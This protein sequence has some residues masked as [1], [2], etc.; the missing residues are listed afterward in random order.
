MIAI[1]DQRKSQSPPSPMI[2][3]HP[4]KVEELTEEESYVEHVAEEPSNDE[5]RIEQFDFMPMGTTLEGNKII[6]PKFSPLLKG[7]FVFLPFHLQ[8]H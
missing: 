5:F 1:E 3:E 2:E 8:L 4:I 7:H 6:D